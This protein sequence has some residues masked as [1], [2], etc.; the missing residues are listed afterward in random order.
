M[1]EV[2]AVYDGAIERRGRANNRSESVFRLSSNSL[3]EIIVLQKIRDYANVLALDH[4]LTDVS[5]SS[6][7]PSTATSLQGHPSLVIL[8]KFIPTTWVQCYLCTFI[9]SGFLSHILLH[10]T[11]I[12][13]SHVSLIVSICFPVPP[14]VYSLHPFFCILQ[15]SKSYRVF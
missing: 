11:W 12:Q 5:S 10:H 3:F 7:S 13:S 1:V 15:R 4:R 6:S 8:L 2:R 9:P 14:F